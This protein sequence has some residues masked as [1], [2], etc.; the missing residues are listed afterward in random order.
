MVEDSTGKSGPHG[1][2]LG[3]LRVADFSNG[4]AGVQVGQFM[5]DYGAD[6]IGIE[7]PGGVSL[8]REPAWPF[9]GRGRRSVMLD[10]ADGADREEARHLAASSDVVIETFRPGVAERL[11]IGYDDLARAN[12]RM[13]YASITGFGRRG[14]LA[15]LQGY[16]GVVM[17][18][19]GV[20]SSLSGMTARPGP[21]FPSARYC[22]F[23]ASQLAAQGVLAALYER[24]TSGRGQRVETSLAQ[25]LTV[26]D[27]FNWFVRVLAMRY[28]D[29]YK[30]APVSSEG[31]PNSG[32]S[33]RLLIALTADGH[34]MQF[35]QTAPRLFL[36]M[37]RAFGLQWM[38]DDPAW[39]DAPDFDD[40]ERRVAFWERL[41]NVVRSK[42][43]DEW[44]VVFDQHPDVW[45]ET[46]RHGNEVLDHPQMVWNGMVTEIDDPDLG[47]VRQPGPLVKVGA[48]PSPI[49]PPAPPRPEAGS[50][51]FFLVAGSDSGRAPAVTEPAPQTD[52]E[53]PGEG[54][55][56]EAAAAPL[57]GVTVLELGTYYAAPFGATLLADLGATVIKIEQLDGDPMRNMLAFPEVAGIKALQGKLSAA[58]DVATEA[59]RRIVRDLVLTADIVLQSFR[60][61][62]AERLGLDAG[63]L[64]A[65]N[66]D[67]VYL[68]APGYGPDG[69]YG[70]RPAYAPTIGAAAGL[71]WRNAGS[72]IAER[73][74]L[75]LDEIKPTAMR[76]AMAVMGVGNA[77]GFAA[78]GVGTA[79][80]L[81]LVARQR[82][83]GARTML[84]T[85]V[86]TAAHALS[87]DMVQYQGRAATAQAD[88]GL[89][90]LHA[91]YRLYETAD[92][93]VFLAAPT[94]EEWL[95]LVH[96]DRRFRDLGTDPRFSGEDGRSRSDGEL[97]AALAGVFLTGPAAGWE[98]TLRA[99][100]VAC[101]AVA[102]GPVEANLIDDG[103]IGR[104]SG[105]V[106]ETTHPLFD[107]VSRL[108]PL[109][110]F[111]RSSTVAGGA[112][113]VGDRTDDVL[114]HLGYDD[115]RIEAL[116]QAGVIGG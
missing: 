93:W 96:A 32:M 103:S 60:A 21:S 59:G 37:M 36:A 55:D 61:G 58:I 87:E 38:L 23:P 90:G 114:R 39:K 116:R 14:P 8:R 105:F 115:Q 15:G 72:S 44:R 17:A 70:H 49:G 71:A 3:G 88:A 18:K 28:G 69:P 92:G 99:V 11:G 42:T 54:R 101:V 68:S 12:P 74:D 20:M 7:P 22:S 84:T 110:T 66:P 82:G 85:M 107:N 89:H 51:P 83:A 102:P 41:L 30:Q 65:L 112:G 33:F 104:Q 25:G 34:W 113:L 56:Q 48:D 43:V 1:A 5:A 81:G 40:V 4:V 47:R 108:A 29:A 31:I 24:E 13:V 27:T 86:S 50:R 35:S 53:P 67:L 57:A 98:A 109:V 91:L 73:A 9:W 46:F 63:T 62:V 78:V 19:L 64:C 80:L 111:S 77:D 10:L 52:I 16:E 97:T 45:A 75:E 76:L 2:P 95:R 100:D 6:V 26:H 79:L 94:S 106:T